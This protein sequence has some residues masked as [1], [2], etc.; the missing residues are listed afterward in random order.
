MSIRV[1]DPRA[2]EAT[3]VRYAIPEVDWLSTDACSPE[4]GPFKRACLRSSALGAS[5]Y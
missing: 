2:R 4:L 5:S 3:I 1:D